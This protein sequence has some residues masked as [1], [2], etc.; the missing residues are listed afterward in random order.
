[1]RNLPVPRPVR[2]P[3]SIRPRRG[4][5]ELGHTVNLVQH[6][7]S[8]LVLPK[9]QHWLDELVAVLSRF[10]VEVK[11]TRLLVGDVARQGCFPD[12]ARTDDGNGRLLLQGCFDKTRS[13]LSIAMQIEYTVFDLHGSA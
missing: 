9:E 3:W 13:I 8:V 5:E 2:R 6:N 12:L 10:K 4:A 1:M 11:R 7:Q